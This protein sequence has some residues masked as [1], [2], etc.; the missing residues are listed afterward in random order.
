MFRSW[1]E[2]HDG[3][4]EAH[5]KESPVGLSAGISLVA[6]VHDY[7]VRVRLPLVG[8]AR[9]LG[10]R[11][12]VPEVCC[13]CDTGCINNDTERFETLGST[14]ARC[15][16]APARLGPDEVGLV[17]PNVVPACG[18]AHLHLTVTTFGADHHETVANDRS[19]RE[20]RSHSCIVSNE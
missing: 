7:S 20:R 4:D 15:V 18:A 1:F 10:H 8:S 14:D 3:K 5:R 16:V 6:A 11:N 9:N 2:K 17:L 12:S 13:K 19:N